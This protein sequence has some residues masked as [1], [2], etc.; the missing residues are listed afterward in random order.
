MKLF[1]LVSITER[2]TFEI[3][4]KNVNF[5]ADFWYNHQRLSSLRGRRRY[6]DVN[7]VEENWS[8]SNNGEWNSSWPPHPLRPLCGTWAAAW[9]S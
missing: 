9:Q 2:S 1:L 8:S 5:V 7:L 6:Y 3:W 4:R